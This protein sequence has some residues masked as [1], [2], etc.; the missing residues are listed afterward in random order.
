MDISNR[1]DYSCSHN[2]RHLLPGSGCVMKSVM[3]SVR[4]K[5]NKK[6]ENESIH[7]RI[8]CR[9]PAYR[10]D[11]LKRS[12]LIQTKEIQGELSI[13][14]PGELKPG[15]IRIE[16]LHS[17]LGYDEL[18]VEQAQEGCD[19]WAS[20]KDRRYKFPV[21]LQSK[22]VDVSIDA[23]GDRFAFEAC[24]SYMFSP[25]ISGNVHFIPGS[26]IDQFCFLIPQS[27][28]ERAV[29]DK[30]VKPPKVVIE[31]LENPNNS[32]YYSRKIRLPVAGMIVGNIRSCGMTGSLR[33]LYLE[34]KFMEF[35]A[36]QLKQI[37]LTELVSLP[38]YQI[39]ISSRDRDSIYDAM[40]YLTEHYI[41]TA[42]IQ[43]VA[44]R[45]GL[46][47]TKLKAGFKREF[48]CTIF[49][50]VHRLRMK[51]ALMLLCDTRMSISEVA[52]AV[53][54]RSL[55]AFSAAFRREMGGTPSSVRARHFVK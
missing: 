44:R 7:I 40:V 36:L 10:K 46:N 49:D 47:S 15:K 26:A 27:I 31:L 9:K 18:V 38:G 54:Y 19:L 16:E 24:A 28:L 55:S 6:L 48:G 3:K 2:N 43:E 34:A 53:G 32:H 11:S 13:P 14:V 50:Y 25:G 30:K 39:N 42:T 35:L 4:K 45:V 12:S 21:V 23:Q 22:D 51:K 8:E 33:S 52:Q 41:E 5:K 29:Q 1:Q 37:Y 20:V 17:G